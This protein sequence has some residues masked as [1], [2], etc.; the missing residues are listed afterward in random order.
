MTHMDKYGI[1]LMAYS[2]MGGSPT[3]SNG[4]SNADV[5]ICLFSNEIINSLAKKY[6][7]SIGQILIKYQLARGNIVIVKSVTKSRIEENI[8][9]LDF[10]LNEEEVQQL[11]DLNKNWRFIH[12]KGTAYGKHRNNP[13]NEEY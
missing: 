2:P 9:V 12:L 8:K 5:R 1:K 11:D 4:F 10:K 3:E 6:R 13:F 7:K